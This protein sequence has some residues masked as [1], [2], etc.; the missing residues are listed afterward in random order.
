MYGDVQSIYVTWKLKCWQVLPRASTRISLPSI[1]FFNLLLMLK[2]FVIRKQLRNVIDVHFVM[3]LFDELCL[4]VCL[5]A[6]L[7]SLGMIYE[8]GYEVFHPVE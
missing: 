7:N 5:M 8:F 3:A 2:G 4:E 1:E 6:D